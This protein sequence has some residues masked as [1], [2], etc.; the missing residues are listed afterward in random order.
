MDPT[1]VIPTPDV[2]K[3]SKGDALNLV[4]TEVPSYGCDP[5]ITEGML[6][7]LEFYSYL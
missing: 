2:P 7:R 5:S 4:L 1:P 6:T 3:F